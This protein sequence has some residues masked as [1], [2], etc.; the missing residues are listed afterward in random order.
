MTSSLSAALAAPVRKNASKSPLN[1]DFTAKIHHKD[2]EDTKRKHRSQNPGV[3]RR[4]LGAR[5]CSIGAA[6]KSLPSPSG[7]PIR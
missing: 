7:D 2:T 4:A 5:A 6:Y 3:R 1:S